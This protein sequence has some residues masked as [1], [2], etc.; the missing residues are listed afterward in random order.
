ME[1]HI[2]N[3]HFYKH[4]NI[5]PYLLRGFRSTVYFKKKKVSERLSIQ[6]SL[7]QS[8]GLEEVV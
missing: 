7:A 4:K 1:L 3:K 2:N 8:K 5:T 6:S